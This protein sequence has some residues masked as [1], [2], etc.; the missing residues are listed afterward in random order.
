[1]RHYW[2]AGRESAHPDAGDGLPRQLGAAA[3][4]LQ[5]G[6]A[7]RQQRAHVQGELLQQQVHTKG[8]LR[9]WNSGGWKRYIQHPAGPALRTN[10][11]LGQTTA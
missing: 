5:R 11:C 4:A 10:H 1:M 6:R 3:Q 7:A 9:A 2:Q 8:V